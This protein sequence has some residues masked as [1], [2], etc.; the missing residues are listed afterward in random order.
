MALR[1]H[2]AGLLLCGTAAALAPAATGAPDMV[3]VYPLAPGQQR[4]AV[5]ELSVNGQPVPVVDFHNN[6]RVEYRYAQFSFSGS[7]ELKVAIKD[8]IKSFKIRP[9]AYGIPGTARD[10]HLSF[11]LAQSRYLLININELD[12]LLIFAD[13]LEA[14][15]PPAAGSG[16][17]N[18]GAAPYAADRT[19]VAD[20]T[21]ILQRAIDDAS[22]VRGTVYVPAGMYRISSITLKRD[23]HL[24]LEGGAVLRGTGRPADYRAVN[25]KAAQY[26]IRERVTTFIQ[27]EPRA[28]NIR[29]SGRGTLDTNGYE[30]FDAKTGGQLRM[31]AVRPNRN[32]Q[33][34]IEGVII[35]RSRWWALTPHQCDGV[36]IENVKVLSTEHRLNTDAI[37]IISCQNVLV[38]HCFTYGNDD[39]LCVKPGRAGNFT[40]ILEPPDEPVR[41]VVFDDV[42]TYNRTHACKLGYQG[43][44]HCSDVW[45]KNIEAL[46]TRSGIG[47]QHYQNDGVMED[48]HFVNINVEELVFKGWKP[49]PFRLEIRRQGAVREGARVRNVEITNVNFQKFGDGDGPDGYN[50]QNSFIVG[51]SDRSIIENVAF[52][53]LRIAGRLIL[54]AAS[55]RVDIKEFARNVTFASA[56]NGPGKRE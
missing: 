46:K 5:L 44:T 11:R 16:I 36:R 20:V 6:E 25:T 38:R 35:A 7:V 10:G 31:N 53:D 43:A 15:A 18:V 8:E 51:Q 3:R 40:G 1:W 2:L 48:I 52:T 28:A 12:N 47:I 29:I 41:H 13:P 54:D 50:G 49:S 24:Y 34:V 23:V 4:S 56:G 32:K 19:G 17:L 55:G 39:A 26:G 45:F 22:A 14:D 42:V 27:F 9:E 30:L 21:K 33:V 37:D